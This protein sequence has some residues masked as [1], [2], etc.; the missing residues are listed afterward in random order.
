MR[1]IFQNRN[2]HLRIVTDIGLIGER[3]LDLS[4]QFVKVKMEKYI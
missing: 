1:L 3:R 2:E 4:I